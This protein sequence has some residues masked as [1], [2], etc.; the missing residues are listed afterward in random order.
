MTKARLTIDLAA[1]AANWRQLAQRAG[2]ALCAAVVK[3]DAYGLGAGEVAPVLAKA[4]CG[5]FFVA[6]LGEGVALRKI[7]GPDPAI[8]V[9][10]GGPLDDAA[11]ALFQGHRLE[12]VLSSLPEV[13]FWAR[14][15]QSG[16]A[17]PACAVHFDTGMN[18]LGLQAGDGAATAA[19]APHLVMSHFIVSETPADP[20]NNAQIARFAEIRAAFPH[21]RASLANSSGIFLGAAALHDLVRP[22]FALYGGNPCPGSPNPMRAVVQLD[23]PLL[24]LRDVAQGETIG[25]GGHFTAP[26]AMRVAT[27]PLGYADGFA[28]LAAA[29]P[30][31]GAFAMLE[32]KACPFLGRVSMDLS[33]IDVSA[34]PETALRPGMM[35]QVLGPAISIDECAARSGRI[36]YE[37]LTSLGRRFERIYR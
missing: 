13:A 19:V 26:R 25:Y 31:T 29:A 11:L 8:F 14:A 16:A 28:R 36:G 18:R 17:L 6:H 27:L 20:H 15:R 30:D 33:V 12:P 5:T 9:L 3:A 4:G 21:A 32:G 22:G 10:N 24:M 7:I 35:A 2:P 34:I 1:I 23:V 37:V